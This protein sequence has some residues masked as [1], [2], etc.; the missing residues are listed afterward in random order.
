MKQVRHISLSAL[1]LAVSLLLTVG[2]AGCSC[3]PVTPAA[4]SPTELL[5]DTAKPTEE[6]SG[7]WEVVL[8]LEVEQT[9]RMAAFLDDKVGYT[10]GE[11]SEGR[12]HYT[13]DGGQTW[14]MAESSGG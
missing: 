2:T 8:D 4:S 3:A 10:G 5:A 14:T 13:T 12:A 6:D 7:S 9:L 11:A 1:S